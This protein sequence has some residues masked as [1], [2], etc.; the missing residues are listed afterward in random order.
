MGISSCGAL[1]PN[2]HVSSRC[3]VRTQRS[4]PKRA[5]QFQ[6]DSSE[7]QTPSR[8]PQR[9]RVL[10][11]CS[12][13]NFAL[14]SG[15]LHQLCDRMIFNHEPPR[16]SDCQDCG[17]PTH[18]GIKCSALVARKVGGYHVCTTIG[19]A[20]NSHISLIDEKNPQEGVAVKMSTGGP[21]NTCSL[22]VSVSCDSNGVQGPYSLDKVGNCDYAV[23]LRHP[24]GCPTVISF[25]GRGWGWFGTFI[26]ILLCLLGGYMLAGTVYRFFF[27]GIHGIEAV[28]NLDFWRSLPRQSQNLLGSLGRRFRRQP[29]GNRTMYSPVNF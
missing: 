15:W 14:V 27:L 4:L 25:H 13:Q 12:E 16:C 22:T 10:Q 24:Y 8:N 18:C 7:S 17:G 1:T 2:P 11:G 29:Q 6:L 19:Q 21:K 3:P 5:L 28:P 23:A 20:S 9:R 26:T